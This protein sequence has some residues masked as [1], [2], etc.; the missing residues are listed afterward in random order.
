MYDPTHPLTA[1]AQL[2]NRGDP[3][4]ARNSDDIPLT[5][6]YDHGRQDSFASVDTITADKPRGAPYDP[7]GA[8]PYPSEPGVAY[9]QEPNPTPHARDSYYYN[10]SYSEGSMPRPETAQPH[11]GA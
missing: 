4:D 6:R 7:Y 3:W 2:N 9:M 1:D 11:P 5:S 10:T 8:N